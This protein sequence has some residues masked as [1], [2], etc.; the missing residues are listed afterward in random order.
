[1][2]TFQTLSIA[3]SG[4]RAQQQAMDITAHNIANASTPGYHRQQVVLQTGGS[5]SMQIP[6]GV[7][8]DTIRRMQSDYVDRQVRTAHDWLGDWEYK[9][10]TLQQVEAVLSE[11]GELGLSTYLNRF[12]NAWEELS[13]SPESQPARMAVVES[14]VAL[15]DRFHALSQSLRDIQLGADQGIVDNTAKINQLAR[16]VSVLN[17]QISRAAAGGYPPNDLL[18][19]RDVLLDELSTLAGIQIS[20]ASEGELMICL[21]GKTLVQG[22]HVNEISVQTGPGG[23]SQLVWAEDGSP[24]EIT[25]GQVAGQ[26]QIRDET[27]AGYIQSLDQIAQTV[28]DRVN[29]LHS[30]GKTADGSPAGNFFLT[31]ATASTI[32]VESGLIANPSGVATSAT[33][34]PGDNQLA[35]AIAAIQGEALIDNQT[36]GTAYSGLVGAIGSHSREA[37][38]RCDAYTLSFDQL[39]AQRESVSGV[40]LDEE[41]LDMVKFQQAYAASAR[42]VTVI[43][44][45]I[46]VIINRMGV[47]GG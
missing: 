2:P 16:E 25:G 11:P 34:N 15:S 26:L 23:W 22:V 14:G 4:L 43:N 45:M 20:G 27:I 47:A 9:K 5:R 36:I 24:V 37:I 46:D 28:A 13:A 17:E 30:T 44:E 21:S 18:D 6:T 35:L 38:S 1:M 42:V 39:N 32:Q 41:M 10:E 40:S 33:D 8:V 7:M 12:W 3:M 31:G 29:A 19:Q